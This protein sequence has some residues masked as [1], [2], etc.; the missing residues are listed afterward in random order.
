MC[1]G[2]SN[3]VIIITIFAIQEISTECKQQRCVH[4]SASLFSFLLLGPAVPL[5]SLPVRPLLP[6]SLL[7]GNDSRFFNPLCCPPQ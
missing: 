2:T 7:I 5:F 1:R 6:S 4:R 3:L